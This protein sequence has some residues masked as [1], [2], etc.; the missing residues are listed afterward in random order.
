MYH[1]FIV[2][3]EYHLMTQ[4]EF[5][6]VIFTLNRLFNLEDYYFIL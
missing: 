6:R 2:G 5:K 1:I 3:K 4:A